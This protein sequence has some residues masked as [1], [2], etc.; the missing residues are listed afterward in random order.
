MY[1]QLQ[2]SCGFTLLQEPV[3]EASDA[4]RAKLKDLELSVLEQNLEIIF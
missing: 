4:H 1:F 2:Q 3:L